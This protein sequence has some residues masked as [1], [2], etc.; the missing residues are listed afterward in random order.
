MKDSA[1]TIAVVFIL[2]TLAMA[3]VG[4]VQF[5]SAKYSEQVCR[6]ACFPFVHRQ[7]AGL[8]YCYTQEGNL[9]LVDKPEAK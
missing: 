3:L 8:C 2:L 4:I 7:V 1:Y 9:R 5:R 6:E